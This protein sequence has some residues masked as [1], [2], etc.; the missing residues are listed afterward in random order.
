MLF[1]ERNE[2]N[3]KRRGSRHREDERSKRSDD[4]SWGEGTRKKARK[5]IIYHFR[6]EHQT[7]GHE[8]Q[9]RDQER[10]R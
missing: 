2:L 3:E 4:R 10:R 9:G 7:N 6:L 8:Q 1:C 5:E